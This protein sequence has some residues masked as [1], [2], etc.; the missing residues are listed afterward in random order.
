M[1]GSL[2]G[3]ITLN[4][5]EIDENEYKNMYRNWRQINLSSVFAR[6]R[7]TNTTKLF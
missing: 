7:T 5:D 3:E 6:L 1:P 4:G 2:E